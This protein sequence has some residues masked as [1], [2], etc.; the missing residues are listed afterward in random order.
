[1][2]YLLKNILVRD[3]YL[4]SLGICP[5]LAVANSIQTGWTMGMVFLISI[6]A[7]S[8]FLSVVRN[9]V[10]LALRLTAIVLVSAATLS[11]LHIFLQ[12]WM[13]EASLKPGIYVPLMAM[14]CLVLAQAEECAL[15]NNVARSCGRALAAG[16][17]V[18][19]IVLALGTVREYASLPLLQQ[20]PG[21][22]LLLALVIAGMQWL[23]ARS[24][25]GAAAT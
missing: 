13:Y 2:N 4:A 6:T 14:N 15:R 21:A 5:L 23:A 10:P 1:M 9:L 24:G 17:G 22:F 19:L 16:T 12:A 25:H 20:P 18:L 8:L 7:V 3:V 11:L